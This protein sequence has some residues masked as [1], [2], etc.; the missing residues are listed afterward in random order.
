MDTQQFLPNWLQ[1]RAEL[2]PERLAIIGTEQ[3]TYNELHERT[4]SLARRLASLGVTK[5][6]HVALLVKNTIDSVVMIHALQ[7][8][9]SVMV[10]LN[11][12]LT[13]HEM[14]WQI[15]D[16][17]VK[18]II[19]EDEFLKLVKSIEIDQTIHCKSFS[20]V[21]RLKPREVKFQ[22]E[23]CLDDV[24]T[25][26]YTSG[27]T[28]KPKGV[29]LTYGNHWWSAVGSSLNLGLDVRDRWLCCLPIF[30]VG[31][32]SILM[33]SVF[34]GI[35]TV[36]EDGFNPS[37]INEVIV[38]NQVTI[39]SVVSAMLTQMIETLPTPKS[40]PS[41]L[42]CVLLGGGP[43]PKP[44]LEKC[45]DFSIPVFQT[46]GMTET[47]SQIVT[48]SPEY[49]LRKL[50]SAGKPLF[51]SQ[52]KIINEN[53][54]DVGEIVVKGPNVTKGYYNRKE[55]THETIK[56][57]WLFTGDLG[58]LDDDGFLYV[59]D[60]RSDLIISGGENVYPAEVES[61]LLGHPLVLEAGVVGI[62]DEKWGQVPAAF[63]KVEEHISEEEILHFCIEKLARYKVPKKVY[64][65][66]TLPRNASNK[67]LRRKLL[68]FL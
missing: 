43:A 26:M 4:I 51:P 17:N 23:F 42:R 67:L 46:Y 39:I 38:K 68:E 35:T 44:L 47:A 6:D 48:L 9:G 52:L 30:H 54:H 63:I 11:T 14:K 65:I 55:E 20:E 60:R 66:N 13:I 31:G 3:L 21:L 2:T 22:S 49:M 25:I 10:L 45:R 62:E 34:Y 12:R 24:H 59:V 58:Y 29:M 19:L 41:F 50:G 7:Y 8:L 57:G 27:T 33:R 28:G 15:E 5:G 16:A 1:K 40:Y 56:D 36:L 64:F 32:L 37:K 53:Q 18:T 61:V